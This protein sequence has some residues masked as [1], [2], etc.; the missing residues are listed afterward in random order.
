[1]GS[2]PVVA[3]WLVTRLIGQL[4]RLLAL[5]VGNSLV[6]PLVLWRDGFLRWTGRLFASAVIGLFG[7]ELIVHG[8]AATGLL[9]L[10]AWLVKPTL[11]SVLAWESK[12]VERA[13]DGW[14]IA[15]GY[16]PQLLEATDLLA[17]AGPSASGGLVGLLRPRGAPIV[18]RAT[19]IRMA[20]N[21]PAAGV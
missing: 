4:A 20:V 9:L 1:L 15:A 2:L 16:G 3:A 10:I 14:T 11:R 13:A 21:G 5:A 7:A 8:F 19:R 6:V 12:R 18:E 17:V